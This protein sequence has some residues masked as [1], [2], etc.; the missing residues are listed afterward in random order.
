MTRDSATTHYEQLLADQLRV[1][2][3]NYPNTLTTRSN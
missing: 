1:L 3:P 2:G